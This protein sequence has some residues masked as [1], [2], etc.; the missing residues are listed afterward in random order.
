MSS[1]HDYHHMPRCSS[2][3]SSY[4]AKDVEILITAMFNHGVIDREDTVDPTMPRAK[5]NPARMNNGTVALMD[6][7]RAWRKAKLGRDARESVYLHYGHGDSHT[8]ISEV[9]EIDRT[10]VSRML[11]RSLQILTDAIN[12]KT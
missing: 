9:F 4:Q 3:Q 1:N 12:G 8:L 5:G 6:I 10:A 7:E 11:D 2:C